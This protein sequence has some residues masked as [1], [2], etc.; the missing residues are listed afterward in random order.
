M[1][2]EMSLERLYYNDPFSNIIISC[3]FYGDESCETLKCTLKTA[4]KSFENLG[5]SLSEDENNGLRLNHVG[6][7][8][9]LDNILYSDLDE[10]SILKSLA[11]YPF[12]LQNGETLRI[13]IQTKALGYSIFFCMHHI[14]GD[15]NSLILLIKKFI[16]LMQGSDIEIVENKKTMQNQTVEID[17]Q[18]KYLINTINRQ[19]PRKQYSRDDYFSMHDQVYK[20]NDLDISKITLC[21]FVKHIGQ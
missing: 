15:A 17:L 20:N 16:A 19:Y 3:D 4:I 6:Y 14:I 8:R 9:N 1:S 10:L 13:I 12:D 2:K 21:K 18:T 11:E 5:M 7:N